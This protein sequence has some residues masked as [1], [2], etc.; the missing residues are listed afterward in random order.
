MV[1]QIPLK[2]AVKSEEIAKVAS[3]LS[4]ELSN[5][6]VGQ[7]IIVDGGEIRI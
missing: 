4:S 1:K 7:T 5:G 6:I 3:F 2:R